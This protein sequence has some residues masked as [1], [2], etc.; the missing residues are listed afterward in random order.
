[1]VCGEKTSRRG[2]LAASPGGSASVGRS[3]RAGGGCPETQDRWLVPW[4]NMRVT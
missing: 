2:D 3:V 4:V 1:M